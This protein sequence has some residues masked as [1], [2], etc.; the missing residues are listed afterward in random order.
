VKWDSDCVLMPDKI[1][2]KREPRETYAETGLGRLL[3][4]RRKRRESSSCKCKISCILVQTL[5]QQEHLLVFLSVILIKRMIDASM[6]EAG[7]VQ[8]PTLQIF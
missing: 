7:N 5:M 3:K 4:L 2:R 1:K 6:P 8:K